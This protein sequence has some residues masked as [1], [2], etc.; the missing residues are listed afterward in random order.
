MYELGVAVYFIASIL[1]GG[2]F[3]KKA[4]S[5]VEPACRSNSY[6]TAAILCFFF[7]LISLFPFGL[8]AIVLIFIFLMTQYGLGFA[9]ALVVVIIYSVLM[10]G[11]K[12]IILTVF[13]ATALATA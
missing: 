11:F 7:A 1:L 8:L 12:F 9:K 13:F 6:I 5:M 10:F 2:L 4:V 3:L